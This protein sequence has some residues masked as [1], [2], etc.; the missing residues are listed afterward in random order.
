MLIIES[1]NQALKADTS[2]A[3]HGVRNSP[4]VIMPQ[5]EKAKNRLF[6]PKYKSTLVIINKAH[7]ARKLNTLWHALRY[8]VGESRFTMAMSVTPVEHTPEV[9][10]FPQEMCGQGC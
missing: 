3:I 10:V 2:H 7:E 9:S 4:K 1:I 6:D 8:I 5:A